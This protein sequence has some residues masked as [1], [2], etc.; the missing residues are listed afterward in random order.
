MEATRDEDTEKNRVCPPSPLPNTVTDWARMQVLGY[1]AIRA[2]TSEPDIRD[3]ANRTTLNPGRIPPERLE[4]PLV[5]A[6][7]ERYRRHEDTGMAR[8]EGFAA[9]A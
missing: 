5:V 7:T 9:L 3:W 2:I 1:R 8:L 4:D 6:A